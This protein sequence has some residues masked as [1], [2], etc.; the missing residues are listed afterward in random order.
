MFRIARFA[1]SFA[2]LMLV[3]A[4]M[5]RAQQFSCR[6]SDLNNNV[7]AEGVAELVGDL[8]LICSGGFPRPPGTVLPTYELIVSSTALLTSRDL[9][10]EGSQ[11]PATETLLLIDEPRDAFQVGCA[12]AAGANSCP[13]IAGDARNANVFQGRR[14]QD[15]GIVFQGI[16]I[17]PPGPDGTRTL[18]ITNLRANIADLLTQTPPGSVRVTVQMFGPNGPVGISGP[19]QSLAS[20]AAAYSFALRTANDSAPAVAGPPFTVA[21]GSLTGTPSLARSIN[22]RF[23]EGSPTAFRRRNVAT[24]G[25]DPVLLTMQPIPGFTYYTESGLFNPLLPQANSLHTS[26]LS[27]T[28]TRLRVEF[29]NIPTGATLWVTWRDVQAGTTRFSAVVPKAILTAADEAGN[30][31]LS[32]IRPLTGEYVALSATQGRA[33]AVW[34]VV[35]S[36]PGLLEDFSFNVAITGTTSTSLGTVTARGMLAPLDQTTTTPA[37]GLLPPIQPRPL[38]A[39]PRFV[40]PVTAIPQAALAVSNLFIV[41]PFSLVSGASFTGPRV[42]PDSIVSG[43]GNTQVTTPIFSSEQLSTTLGTTSVDVIDSAGRRQSAR[44]LVVTPTQVNFLLDAQTALGPAIANLYNG[45]TLIANGFLQVDGFAPSLFSATGDGRGFAVGESVRIQNSVI[46]G[47]AP[48]SRFDPVLNR[49]TSV[50]VDFG[51]PTDLVFLSLFGTGLRGRPALSSVTA[52]IGGVSVPVT[53]AGPQ[54]G[55]VGLDQINLGPVP[56]SLRNRGVV[57]VEIEIAGKTANV[58]NV[59]LR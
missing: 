57:P 19:V 35:S 36:E 9:P 22:V 43:F 6:R 51:A 55:Y 3:L 42:A 12:P 20:P 59:E 18:R 44:L 21:P 25:L 46:V 30:G 48:L 26:G 49:Q 52:R 34:E 33:V 15:N 4:S 13:G 56:A 7:R 31:L 5:M 32:P 58:L 11:L 16:P 23:R 50:P 47:T 39:L 27:D 10:S 40:I 1:A 37:A 2:L 29:T 8:V 53:F 38:P 45:T 24:S 28:G 17:D 41:P 54:G 14:L